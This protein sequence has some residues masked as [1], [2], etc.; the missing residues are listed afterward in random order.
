MC[1]PGKQEAGDRHAPDIAKLAALGPLAGGE[2]PEDDA[3]G[4]DVN[5]VGAAPAHEQLWSRPRKRP[6]HLFQLAH[7]PLAHRVTR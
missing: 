5:L 2:L 6:R 4:V 3:K 1:F 7:V